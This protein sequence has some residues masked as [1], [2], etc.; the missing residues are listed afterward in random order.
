M[1]LALLLLAGAWLAHSA[2]RGVEA[3]TDDPDHEP[4]LPLVLPALAVGFALAWWLAPR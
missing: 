4:A 1:P 2:A 3:V